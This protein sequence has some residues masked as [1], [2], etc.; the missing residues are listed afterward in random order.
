MREVA[1]KSM[2]DG[3][4]LKPEVLNTAKNFLKPN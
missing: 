4:V 2:K 1:E 3:E